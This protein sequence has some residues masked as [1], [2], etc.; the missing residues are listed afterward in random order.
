MAKKKKEEV[1]VLEYPVKNKALRFYGDVM[2]L[3]GSLFTRHGL[4]FGG[5]YRLEDE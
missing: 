4:R 1:W 2:I 3:L 5:T